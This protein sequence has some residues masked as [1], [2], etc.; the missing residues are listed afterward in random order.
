VVDKTGLQ[1]RYLFTFSWDPNEHYM[2]AVEELL[3]LKFVSEKAALEFFVIDHIEKP[4][5]N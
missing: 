2:G 3:G 5:P 4:D 1:G